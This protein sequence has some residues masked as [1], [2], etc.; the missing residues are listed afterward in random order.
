MVIYY[1]IN[2]D[3]FCYIYPAYTC[4]QPRSVVF[5]EILKSGQKIEKIEFPGNGY[6]TDAVLHQLKHAHAVRDFDK[7]L[8]PN[9]QIWTNQ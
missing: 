1:Y 2:G 6:C 5:Q 9:W 4:N 8:D 7:D 3:L